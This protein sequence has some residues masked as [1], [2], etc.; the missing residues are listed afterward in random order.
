MSLFDQVAGMVSGGDA[1]KY[2][3]ILSWI[4]NQG[5]IQALLEKFRQGGLGEI[6]ASWL[7][8]SATNQPVSADQ[9]SSAL[10]SPAIADLAGKLGI[11][12]QAASALLAQYLPK[13]VDALSPQGQVDA[14]AGNDLLSAGMN[15]LKGKLFG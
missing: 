15:I 13:V 10:G 6:V 1:G 2:Q 4:N 9:V 8:S 11:D 3:A 14:S 5:G 12:G 7:S